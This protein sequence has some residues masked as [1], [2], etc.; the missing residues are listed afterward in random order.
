MGEHCWL[1]QRLVICGNAI[2]GALLHAV[3]QIMKN[4]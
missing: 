4:E 1:H 2:P 3:N